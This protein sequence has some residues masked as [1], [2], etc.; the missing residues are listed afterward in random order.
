MNFCLY[1]TDSVLQ[2]NQQSESG[3][4]LDFLGN[5][6]CLAPD[7]RVDFPVPTA[8]S[9]LSTIFVYPAQEL[10]DY[11]ALSAVFEALVQKLFF[12]GSPELAQLL[13]IPGIKQVKLHLISDA[14]V[15]VWDSLP[16]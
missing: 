16:T 10:P 5:D 8:V 12:A 9:L 3:N 4:R 6:S 15:S 11:W 14:T 2:Y 7:L 13:D 1:I